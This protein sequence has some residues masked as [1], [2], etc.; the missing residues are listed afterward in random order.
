M[1]EPVVIEFYGTKNP[2]KEIKKHEPLDDRNPGN[3]GFQVFVVLP[4]LAFVED[5]EFW[6]ADEY[7]LST[8]MTLQHGQR[9]V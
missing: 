4:A 2:E 1:D 9:I 3:I 8:Q 7:A 6:G 5:I